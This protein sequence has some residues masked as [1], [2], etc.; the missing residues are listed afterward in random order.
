MLE[1]LKK[2][3]DGQSEPSMRTPASAGKLLAGMRTGDP[4]SVLADLT[5]WIDNG[6]PTEEGKARSE[7]LALIHETA[8]AHVPA[9][10][11]R[12]FASPAGGRA[13][14]SAGWETLANYLM[15]MCR[16]LYSSARSPLKNPD[17]SQKL[18]LVAATDA[19]RCLQ[20]ARMLA[21]ACLMRYLSV[22]PK[23]WRMAYSV[24]DKARLAGCAATPVR[25][26]ASGEAT[27][28]VAH[29]LLK[30]LMLQSSAP[31]R[32]T[33]A[34]IEATDRAVE[35]LGQDFKLAPRGA[36]SPFSFDAS[37][38][39]A[40]RR[41]NAQQPDAGTSVH[42]FGAGG[43]LDALDRLQKQAASAKAQDVKPFGADIDAH[44]QVSAIRHMLTFWA[45]ACA[46]AP[47]ARSPATGEVRIIHGYARIWQELSR[48][49]SAKTELRL[50]DDEEDAPKAAETWILSDIAGD[51]LGADIVQLSG[52][53]PRCG[54]IVAVSM[55]GNAA[56]WPAVIRSMHARRDGRL[57]AE[58][59]IL[60]RDP[61]A[62]EL[63]ALFSK[64]EENAYSQ[65]AA[66]EFAFDRACAIL[67]SDGSAASQ[68][69]NLLLAPGG[70]KEGRVYEATVNGSSRHLRTLQLLRRG[71]DYVRAS[72]EWV[73]IAEE[74]KEAPSATFAAG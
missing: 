43:A 49:R 20:A 39:M 59:A 68:K 23:L 31:E 24:Y 13:K 73:R 22:A 17:S 28:S 46:Y 25:M 65:R 2:D 42:Y 63:R 57:H 14:S 26:H 72:F 54:D 5:R 47:P 62:V 58:I 70:W 7:V 29:E 60:S 9:M 21:K 67:L 1:W 40:P 74:K 69:P 41:W 61:V 12:L 53:W 3:E 66:L 48:A 35:Q 45:P 55:N 38:E 32:M 27:T 37:S 64:G 18:R 30:L 33:P 11:A 19:V 6:I 44:A 8:A 51:E 52:D 36:D 15:A 16:A 10:M 50:V 56:Y 34:E 4:A 71:D